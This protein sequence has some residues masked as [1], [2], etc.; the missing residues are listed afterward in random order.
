M[1]GNVGPACQSAVN[2]RSG[3]VVKVGDGEPIRF[4]VPPRAADALHECGRGILRGRLDGAVDRVKRELENTP[5][6]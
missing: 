5:S 6:R 3:F 2:S 1:D 4:N